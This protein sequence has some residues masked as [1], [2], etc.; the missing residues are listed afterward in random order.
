MNSPGV[1]NLRDYAK[2]VK[3]LKARRASSTPTKRRQVSFRDALV[4]VGR[5]TTET[6]NQPGHENES[7]EASGYINYRDYY[8][9]YRLLHAVTPVVSGDHSHSIGEGVHGLDD[10]AYDST[11][12]AEVCPVPLAGPSSDACIGI[13]I[14]TLT[15]ELAS[16]DRSLDHFGCIV[17]LSMILKA[18]NSIVVV[19][20]NSDESYIGC[21]S[22]IRSTVDRRYYNACGENVDV[23]MEPVKEERPNGI[24]DAV[25]AVLHLHATGI[26]KG[27][28]SP[29]VPDAIMREWLLNEVEF[30]ISQRLDGAQTSTSVHARHILR[31]RTAIRSGSSFST[32]TKEVVEGAKTLIRL[33]LLKGVDPSSP[34]SDTNTELDRKNEQR[35]LREVEK[36][37]GEWGF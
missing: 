26:R 22:V 13:D 9:Q 14:M 31:N 21:D 4:G 36:R 1:L 30:L 34:P 5:G 29:D 28:Q 2:K 19:S 32:I 7:R 23:V 33:L 20:G 15:R 37:A 17:F 10:F 12:S 11:A 6:D 27:Y 24:A 16:C 8:A 3:R 35:V 18:D 25:A